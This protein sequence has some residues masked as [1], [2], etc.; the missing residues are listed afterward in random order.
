LARAT[1]E[2]APGS[3]NWKSNRNSQTKTRGAA[4][5][6]LKK[7]TPMKQFAETMHAGRAAPELRGIKKPFSI[8]Y[9][10]MRVISTVGLLY[11]LTTGFAPAAFIT[12]DE[13]PDPAPA[14]TVVPNGYLGLNWV[15]MYY[16]NG[17]F[18]IFALDNGVVSL[19]NVGLMG[20]DSIGKS[21]L[22][23][24]GV[25]DFKSAWLTAAGRD[26]LNIRVRGYSF[27][28]NGILRY[29][30]TVIV[31]TSGP[32]FFNFNYV[33]IDTLRFD[34]SGGVPAPIGYP[35]KLFLIDDMTVKL[36]GEPTAQNLSIVAP[37]NLGTPIVLKGSDPN[38]LPLG[39]RLF[40]HGTFV[41][42]AASHGIVTG[43]E[44]NLIYTPFPDYLGPDSIRYMVSNGTLTSDPAT[45]SITVKH[46]LSINNISVT[47][48]NSGTKA[49]TFTVTMTVPGSDLNL[50]TVN[51]GTSDGTAKAGSDYRAT[52]GTLIFG[53]NTAQTITVPVIGDRAIEFNESF[54]VQLF[55]AS[56]NA[57]IVNGTGR[58]TILTDDFLQLVSVGT[59]A[60]T[61]ENSV[62]AVGERADL[63][64]TWTHPVGWRQ[65]DS[66][67]LLIL[68]DH[69]AILDT[70]WHEAENSFSLFNPA[71]ARFVRT[72]EAG[73][74]TRFETSALTLD[75]QECTGGGPPGHT[76]TI[77]YSLS[78]KPHAAGRTFSVEAFATDDAGNPQGF[79]SVG[80]M[81][82]LPR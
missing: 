44:P 27:G 77:E 62:V 49:A 18:N 75:V 15:N 30:R 13:L 2:I 12:F 64:L 78:F 73:S 51:Y 48:G 81:T 43:T 67:D 54:L 25:F 37:A 82:V 9:S 60:L 7:E 34:T 8:R 46:G 52:S 79:E 47:E 65:L 50:V 19:S 53:E 20:D 29:D 3:N 10:R 1:V 23:S 38:G 68:D 42:F 57:V 32:T 36:P 39:F 80:T 74:P 40:Y 31:N 72:A 58:G 14:G 63:S 41:T 24:G 76:A 70:R 16:V 26:G 4:S 45:V 35:G 71:A 33:G 59:A 11:A 61:P 21:V 22:V 56:A 69:G 17:H 28:T 55:N 66:V 5:A 6:A